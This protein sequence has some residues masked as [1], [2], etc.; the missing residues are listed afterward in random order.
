[1]TVQPAGDPT[2]ACPPSGQR[3]HPVLKVGGSW[4]VVERAL[5]GNPG[6]RRQGRRD[7]G[8][9]LAAQ[10]ATAQQLQRRVPVRWIVDGTQGRDAH[11]AF[12]GGQDEKKGVK[13]QWVQNLTNI[14]F[15]HLTSNS[16]RASAGTLR[17]ARRRCEQRTQSPDAP[18]FLSARQSSTSADRGEPRYQ[19]IGSISGA[20]C[21]GRHHA[22]AST[23]ILS[24]L[25]PSVANAEPS[26]WAAP[27]QSCNLQ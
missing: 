6:L 5:I 16:S 14:W 13:A 4:S 20:S 3:R 18:T 9:H 26:S 12:A 11:R 15:A 24:L 17:G 1:M 23:L 22:F 27:G 8:H 19:P 21:T 25:N 10:M 7:D 2:K